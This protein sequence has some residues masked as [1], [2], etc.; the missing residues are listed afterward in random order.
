MNVDE[1][2]VV[3][4]KTIKENSKNITDGFLRK[5]ISQR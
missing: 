1:L 3:R 2:K 5:L 4:L